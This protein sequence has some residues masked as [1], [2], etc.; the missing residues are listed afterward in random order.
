MRVLTW[1]LWW[2]YALWRERQE[3]I[4]AVLAEVRPDVCG[5]QEV[6]GTPEANQAADLAD[7]L[8]MHWCLAELPRE[9]RGRVRSARLAGDKP[10]DGVWPADHFAVVA[11]L[12]D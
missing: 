11:E 1:N 4:A 8:G 6:L 9:H 5:L 12:V 2:R 7:W 10:V 3:P